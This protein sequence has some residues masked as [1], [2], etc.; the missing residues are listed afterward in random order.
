MNW[1]RDMTRLIESRGIH[2]SRILEAMRNVPRHEFVGRH[3]LFESYDDHPLPIGFGQTISQP[4]IVA[5]MCDIANLQSGDRVLEIGTG[6]GYHAAVIAQL[7][8]HVYSVEIIPELAERAR[9]IIERLE[10]N[11]ISI[12]HGDGYYGWGEEAPFDAVIVTACSREVPPPLVGQLA[13][14]GRMVI[15]V[16]APFGVQELVLGEKRGQE[17][18]YRETLPVQFV[19][20]TGNHAK[21]SR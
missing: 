10:Y 20:L 3:E 18:V 9:K 13:E 11:N 17:I 15:P 7:V 12:R 2:D 4:Y 19:P 14:G 6:S 5:Y 8:E 16:G 1:A 21:E